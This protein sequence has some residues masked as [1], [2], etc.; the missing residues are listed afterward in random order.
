MNSNSG[1]FVRYSVLTLPLQCRSST[2][3]VLLQCRAIQLSHVPRLYRLAWIF[4]LLLFFLREN[5]TH[6]YMQNVNKSRNT[7]DAAFE[8][9]I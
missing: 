8:T 4:L 9:A 3:P 1:E 7:K 5:D 2:A 6:V